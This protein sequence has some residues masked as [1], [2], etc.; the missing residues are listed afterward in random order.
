VPGRHAAA[1][2]RAPGYP[3]VV[4]AVGDVPLDTVYLNAVAWAFAYRWQVPSPQRNDFTGWR[5][6]RHRTLP[7]EPRWA[8]D[9]MPSDSHRARMLITVYRNGR[10]RAA[11]P[12]P[13]SGDPVFDRSLRTIAT[14]PMPRAPDLPEFPAAAGPDSLLLDVTFGS[15]DTSGIVGIARF[16]GSQAPARVIPGTLNIQAPRR[17]T[18]PSV[19]QRGAIVKYDV[20]AV[21]AVDGNSI[22][23]L[24]SSDR[25]LSDVIRSGLLRAR[26]EPAESNCRP[27][28][29]TVVQRF[30]F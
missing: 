13:V 17:A 30:G 28:T 19:V 10:L 11:D 14:D 7:P 3:L 12:L 1:Q 6:V 2:C 25:E 16:A 24:E 20:T 4:R 26:F 27:I 22:E 21:G 5:R 29:M 8:D 18:T 23:I 9:W 15:A